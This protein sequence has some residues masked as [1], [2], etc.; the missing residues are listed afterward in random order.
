MYQIANY[1]SVSARFETE[2]LAVAVAV[3]GALAAGHRAQ[4]PAR[5][6]GGACGTAAGREAGPAGLTRP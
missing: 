4:E 1:T 2:P 5:D 3:P 6:G